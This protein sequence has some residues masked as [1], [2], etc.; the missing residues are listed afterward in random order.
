MET[1]SGGS[2]NGQVVSKTAGRPVPGATI[3]IV[4]GAGPYPDIAPMTDEGGRFFLD[5]LAAGEWVLAAYG[6]DGSHGQGRITVADGFA[7]TVIIHVG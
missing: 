4:R 6:P 7:A 3:S 1:A 2:V 5:G